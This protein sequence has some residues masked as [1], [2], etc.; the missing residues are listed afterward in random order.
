[1]RIRKVF[2][3]KALWFRN[4]ISNFISQFLDTFI[5]MTLAFYEFGQPISVNTAFLISIILPYWVLKCCMSIVETPLVY[6]G[7]QW[8]TKSE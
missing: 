5:F 8:L 4:N 6:L 2:G 3:K 7:V 1:M